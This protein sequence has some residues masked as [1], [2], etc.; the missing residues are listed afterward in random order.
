MR[1]ALT[2]VIRAYFKALDLALVACLAAMVVMVFG[3][4]VLRY[5]LDSGI[6]ASEELSR[7]VFVWLVFLGAVTGFRDRAHLGMDSVLRA[8]QPGW[9]RVSLALS[10]LVIVG[11][12]AVFIAGTWQQHGFNASTG[13]PVTGLP[14]SWVFGVAYV[15]AGSIAAMALRRFVQALSS[16]AASAPGTL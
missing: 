14:M 10:E 5:G 16:G 15:S 4:V 3:N 12:C 8:L 2:S 6:V 7:F 13:A 1:S 11:C 9:R